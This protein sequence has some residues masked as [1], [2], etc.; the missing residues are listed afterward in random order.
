[1]GDGGS[2]PLVLATPDSTGVYSLSHGLLTPDMKSFQA[3][4][5][6]AFDESLVPLSQKTDFDAHFANMNNGKL[7]LGFAQKYQSKPASLHL[8]FAI[9]Q[10]P[11][12]NTDLEMEIAPPVSGTS[13]PT[14][15]LAF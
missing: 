1:M 14:C 12:G 10:S 8:T 6:T 5:M 4:S 9:G 3:D 11:S 7:E 2:S 13:M 15:L